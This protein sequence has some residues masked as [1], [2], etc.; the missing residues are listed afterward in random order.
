MCVIVPIY[1]YIAYQEI[2]HLLCKYPSC[3]FCVCFSLF[4]VPTL[5][6][7][8]EDITVTEGE[9]VT[10]SCIPDDLRV[11]VEWYYISQ[12]DFP[13]QQLGEPIFSSLEPILPSS[14]VSFDDPEFRHTLT[15]SISSMSLDNGQNFTVFAQGQYLCYPQ[16]LDSLDS[17]ELPGNIT[18]NVLESQYI[19]KLGLPTT[20]HIF[21][22]YLNHVDLTVHACISCCL[23]NFMVA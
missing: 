20:L 4:P 2:N 11:R 14:G 22:S 19:A 18:V 1:L 17:F 21:C 5:A 10:L 13:L 7:F 16:G 6:V 15:L 12:P 23:G 3:F 8:P 9:S